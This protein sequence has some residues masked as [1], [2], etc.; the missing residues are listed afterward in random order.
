MKQFQGL[1]PKDVLKK[2]SHLSGVWY[3]DLF[4]DGENATKGI[5][6]YPVEYPLICLPSNSNFR[7]DVIYHRFGDLARSQS[8][9]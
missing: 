5:K 9:K 4:I 3:E 8:E 6:A 1:R 7:L 2:L